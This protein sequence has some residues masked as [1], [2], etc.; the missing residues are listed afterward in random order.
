MDYSGVTFFW[1]VF[2]GLSFFLTWP[3]TFVQFMNRTWNCRK[4]TRPLTNISSLHTIQATAAPQTS[5]PAVEKDVLAA[6]RRP[7]PWLIIPTTTGS[8]DWTKALY[9]MTYNRPIVASSYFPQN[10]DR[11]RLWFRFPSRRAATLYI[12]VTIFCASYWIVNAPPKNQYSS[13]CIFYY[14]RAKL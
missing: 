4:G 7:Q 2:V 5:I 12:S 11:W 13:S 1:C 8:R 14:P 10:R 6:A 3:S 9:G